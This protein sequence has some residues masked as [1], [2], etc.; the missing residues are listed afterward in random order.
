MSAFFHRFATNIESGIPG[1]EGPQ[2]PQG[3]Q[4]VKGD[5]GEA[6]ERGPQ[7]D[8]GPQGPQGPK[9]DPGGPPGPVGPAGPQGPQGDPG[10]QGPQGPEGPEGPQGPQGLT[11]PQGLQGEPAPEP[12]VEIDRATSVDLSGGA[13]AGDHV[14]VASLELGEGEWTVT[15]RV[16]LFVPD[17]D[18]S[19]KNSQGC[20][21]YADGTQIAGAFGSSTIW[22]STGRGKFVSTELRP[23][24]VPPTWEYEVIEVTGP[25]TVSMECF[26]DQSHSG[27]TPEDR[28]G[29]AAQFI[30]L[31][32]EG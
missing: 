16:N 3:E 28:E 23:W 27:A 5:E 15:G 30:E 11:G 20:G 2:G 32:A 6:G 24:L 10:P 17:T 29:M 13:N 31:R 22:V 14:E 1:P 9:G 19:F 21:I 4:G 18:G 7:G 25:A 8:P 26:I 12:L